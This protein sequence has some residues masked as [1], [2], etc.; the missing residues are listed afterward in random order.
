MA[1]GEP[2]S[3]AAH[4]RVGARV[5]ER[6]SENLFE[7]DRTSLRDR[8][9][10]AIRGSIVTG[11][12]L[13][14]VIYPVSY[15]SGRLG[16]SATPI[17]EALFDLVGDGLIEVVRNRGFRVPRLSDHDLDELYDLRLML[18]V[19]AIGRLALQHKVE[20]FSRLRALALDMVSQAERREVADFLWTDRIF[21]LSVLEGLGNRQLLDVVARLRDRTRLRGIVEMAAS[22]SLVETAKEHLGLLDSLVKQDDE[23][24]KAW[25][26][27]HLRHTRGTW[28]GVT[29]D[30]QL[31]EG[32]SP[33]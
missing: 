20:D 8:A 11:E 3:S 31:T 9:K 4:R 25:M 1:L 16:V 5:A 19:P 14:N 24:A 10:K 30:R 13:E 22:G 26:R 28:A 12:I 17:R 7:L 29:E 32:V 6:A 27:H 21:H 15:F 2:Q 33:P 18:E 23:A